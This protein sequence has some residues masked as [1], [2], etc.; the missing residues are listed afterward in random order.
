[1]LPNSQPAPRGLTLQVA[2]SSG[3]DHMRSI[4]RER[5]AKLAVYHT[6]PA[7]HTT[8]C[9]LVGNFLRPSNDANLVQ[10]P[11]I[12]TEPS[13]HT[14]DP[15]VNDLHE[16][17]EKCQ[18]R[19]DPTK[20]RRCDTHSSYIE[21]VKDLAAALP[22]ICIAV[23]VLAFVCNGNLASARQPR[24]PSLL[25]LSHHKSRIPV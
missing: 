21:I 4:E 1:V 6:C 8:E 22:H 2:M 15:A 12:R 20:S 3:S 5:S 10:R 25:P 7:I 13:M 11:H 9:S 19:S 16:R 24:S 14:Q 18:P 23:F 17:S